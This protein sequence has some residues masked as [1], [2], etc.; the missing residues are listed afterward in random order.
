MFLKEYILLDENEKKKNIEKA[1]KSCMKI[2][3]FQ[4]YFGSEKNQ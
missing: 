3:F 4:K 1:K 2:P